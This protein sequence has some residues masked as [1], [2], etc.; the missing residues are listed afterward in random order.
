MNINHEAVLSA[1]EIVYLVTDTKFLVQT[2]QGDIET[3]GLSVQSLKD[4]YLFK[5]I[6]ELIGLEDILIQVLKGELPQYRLDFVNRKTTTINLLYFN[7]ITIPYQIENNPIQG[8]IHIIQNTTNLGQ[9]HR[10]LVQQR[11]ELRLLQQQP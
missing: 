9:L 10:N 7:M 2:W 6:P 5:V 4:A 11:N 1:C 3:V 8:V